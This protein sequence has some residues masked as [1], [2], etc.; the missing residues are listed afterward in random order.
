ML[1]KYQLNRLQKVI[2]KAARIVFG[3]KPR[4]SIT[5]YLKR[6]HWL[7]IGPRIDF[8]HVLIAWKAEETGEPSYIKA[9]ITTGT[10]TSP[11]RR[12][13]FEPRLPGGHSASRRAFEISIPRLLNKLPDAVKDSSSTC[14]LKKNL[15]TFL[16]T[17]GF[18]YKLHSILEYKPSSDIYTYN[19]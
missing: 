16:F 19:V 15:K 6:L 18:D 5:A 10:R 11:G 4:E 17:E 14:Q 8:K 1:P 9:A 2:N 13:Y 3:L 7:P 12:R